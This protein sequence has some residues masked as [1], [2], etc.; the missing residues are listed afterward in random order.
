[1]LNAICWRIGD[2]NSTRRRIYGHS[3]HEGRKRI[4]RESLRF[5]E[6]VLRSFAFL[7][8]YGLVVMESTPTIVRFTSPRVFLTV[9]HGRNSFELGVEFGRQDSEDALDPFSIDDLLERDTDGAGLDYRN[10]A[11]ST[12]AAVTRGVELMAEDISRFASDALIG[13]TEEYTALERARARRRARAVSLVFNAQIRRE[14]DTAW[15]ER[16]LADVVELL[17]SIAQ[18]LTPAERAKLEYSRKRISD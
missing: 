5:Q 7:T 11:A 15:Q 16:R 13:R 18:D 12:P 2:S 9:F 10:F 17:T 1:M 8:E 6:A 3:I 4:N 14:V